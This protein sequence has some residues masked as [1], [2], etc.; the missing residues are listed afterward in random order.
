M[1]NA[2]AVLIYQS[3]SLFIYAY[4][5]RSPCTTTRLSDSTM[6]TW[7]YPLSSL[8]VVFPLQWLVLDYCSLAQAL[9]PLF[10]SEACLAQLRLYD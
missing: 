7:L 9:M 2:D 3:I 8:R 1:A 4:Y 6:G 10:K 5:S